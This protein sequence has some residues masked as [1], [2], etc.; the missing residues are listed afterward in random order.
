MET[1]VQEKIKEG[2]DK[3]FTNQLSL[4]D[5]KWLLINRIANYDGTERSAVEF[6]LLDNVVETSV[7]LGI[8]YDG[9]WITKNDHNTNVLWSILKPYKLQVMRMVK[10]VQTPI[11]TTKPFVV[12]WHCLTRRFRFETLKFLRKIKYW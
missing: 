6:K 12:E 5:D 3:W 10:Q 8:L 7:V 1:V 9:K 11:D 2:F 4:P